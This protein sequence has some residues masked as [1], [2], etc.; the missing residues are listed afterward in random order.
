MDKDTY[1]VDEPIEIVLAC[2]VKYRLPEPTRLADQAVGK[3]KL[4]T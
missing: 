2:A 4:A 3:L 1:Q